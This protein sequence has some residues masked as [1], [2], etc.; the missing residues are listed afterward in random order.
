[1]KIAILNLQFDNNFGGNLQRYALITILKRMGHDV[2][3][4]NLRFNYD[5]LSWNKKLWRFTKRVRRKLFIDKTTQIF[6]LESYSQRIY[7]SSCSEANKFYN[8]YIHHTKALYSK[9]EVSKQTQ[10]DVY[11]V[12]SDQVW[13]KKYCK[14]YGLHTF[15]FDYLPINKKRIAY[16]ISLGTDEFQF[17]DDIAILST[18]YKR[19]RAVSVRENSAL[20]IFEHYGWTIPRAK[21]VLDPTLLLNKDDYIKLIKDDHTSPSPGNLFCYILDITDEKKQVIENIS[22]DKRL[23]PFHITLNSTKRISIQQ[24]L[25]SFYDASYII[26]DSYHGLLFSIIFNKPFKLIRNEVRGNT[27]FESIINML[28]IPLD[29]EITDWTLINKNIKKWQQ[30]SIDYLVNSLKI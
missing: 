1:M 29:I 30:I 2:T 5:H 9:K 8:K 26:T 15:F 11:I 16:G 7:E 24:W 3:H 4:L 25:R 13:R 6:P 10:Y 17:D 23:I 28:D 20:N 19:F 12:G 27:R 21:L 18:L 22:K 14:M